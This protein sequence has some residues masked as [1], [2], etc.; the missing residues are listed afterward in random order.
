MKPK[1][2]SVFT[3]AC[4]V[5][6]CVAAIAPPTLATD[7]PTKGYN[8][9]IPEK[10]MTADK[11]KTRIGTLEFFDGMPS[12]GTVEKVYDNL[13]LMRGTEAFLNGIPARSVEGLRLGCLELGLDSFNKI[14]IADGSADLYFGPKALTGKEGNW[15]QTVP[16]KSWFAYLRLYGPLE[17]YFDKTW[18]P[19]EFE[20]VK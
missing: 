16:G 9:K 15:V 20:L 3:M 12:K 18:K 14:G 6:M 1:L 8:N 11:V 4:A 19:G 7:A 17:P 2:T 13:D 10:I 5:T